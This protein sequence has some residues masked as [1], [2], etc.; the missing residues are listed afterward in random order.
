MCPTKKAALQSSVL[1]RQQL[2]KFIQAS[3]V[4]TDKL[5]ERLSSIKQVSIACNVTRRS[6]QRGL[7]QVTRIAQRL[8][9]IR[10]RQPRLFKDCLMNNGCNSIDIKLRRRW[11]SR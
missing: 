4:E 5:K 3:H 6:R 9:G 8:L 1:Y 2:H 10:L 11:N 7:R